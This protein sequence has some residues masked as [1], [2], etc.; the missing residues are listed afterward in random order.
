MEV[1]INFYFTI[2]HHI[3]RFDCIGIFFFFETYY[4]NIVCLFII[5]VKYQNNWIIKNFI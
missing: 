3:M 5:L 4:H 1:R 2:S